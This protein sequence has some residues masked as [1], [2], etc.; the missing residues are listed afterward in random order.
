MVK[1]LQSAARFRTLAKAVAIGLSGAVVLGGL[2][3]LALPLLVPSAE[4]RRAATAAITAATGQAPVISGEPTVRLLPSPRVM[5]GKVT[6]PLP[7]GQA[8]DAEDVVTRL[9]LWPLIAGRAEVADVTLRRPTLVITRNGDAPAPASRSARVVATPESTLDRLGRSTLLKT[10]AAVLPLIA[11]ADLPELRIVDGTIALRAPSGLTEELIGG[12]VASLDRSGDRKG[13]SLAVDLLWRD[14]PVSATLLVDDAQ[15]FLAGTAAPTRF[16]LASKGSGLRFR[17]NAALGADPEA[18]GSLS[19][20]TPSLRRLLEW[21]GAAAPM[22]G[23]FGPFSLSARVG[24]EDA[25]LTLADARVE[26]DGNRGEGALLVQLTGARPMIQGTLAADSFSIEPYGR[27]QLMNAQGTGW[28]RSPLDL[29]LLDE[30]DLD[31]R[32]S[33]GQ[34][35]GERSLFTTV[36]ASA[37]LSSGRMVLAVGQANGWGGLIR[38][39]ATLTMPGRLST[40]TLPYGAGIQVDADLTDVDLEK[41]LDD[42]A[43]LRRLEGRGSLQVDLKGEGRSVYDIAQNLSGS[44][45]LTGDAGFLLGFDVPQ[46]LQRIER[47]PLAGGVDMRGGRTAFTQLTAQVAIRNGTADLRQIDIEG[48]QIRVALTGTAALAP[49][50]FDLAGRAILLGP[51]LR[52]PAPPPVADADGPTGRVGERGGERRRAAG[53]DLPFTIRGSWDNPAIMVDPQSLLERSG[54]AQ[55]LMDAVRR[56]TD[57]VLNPVNGGAP[58]T[59]PPAA[60]APN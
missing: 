3:L 55:S 28:D 45:L 22:H 37:V 51:P 40:G 20:E 56:R 53:L 60:A 34:V 4:L 11:K 41:A 59:P 19:V 5:L 8:L 58:T 15:A 26:L 36:A 54:A 25:T 38:A 2:C 10:A 32:L 9:R 43:G 29:S 35:T 39:S 31:L 12:I 6:F 52:E 16:T 17:G 44:L 21:M 33:A 13:V 7:A 27:V 57:A 47:R 50:E 48:R 24:L 14:A 42:I 49:R 46:A 23:G 1:I 30:L 18:D